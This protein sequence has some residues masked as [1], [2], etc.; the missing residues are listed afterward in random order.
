MLSGQYTPRHGVYTVGQTDRGPGNLMR[1]VP[2]PNRL[3]LAPEKVTVAEALKSAGYAT[4]MFGK[5]H[6]GGERGPTIRTNFGR[7]ACAW[8]G[9]A[10]PA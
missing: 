2:I 1:L 7:S 8:G 4:G 9:M 6:L 10:G 3:E 5:W